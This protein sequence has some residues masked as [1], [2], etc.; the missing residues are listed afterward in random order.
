M[1][2]VARA[3][4]DALV[5]AEA[6]ARRERVLVLAVKPDVKADAAFALA[7]A[8]AVSVAMA[9]FGACDVASE[10]DLRRVLDLEANKQLVGCTDDTCLAEVGDALGAK[11]VVYGSLS[12][13]TLTLK[14]WDIA[15]A[16]VASVVEVPRARASSGAALA[17]ATDTLL[18]PVLAN[19][20]LSTARAGRSP[21]SGIS[22]P[23]DP[24][25]RL[26]AF[27]LRGDV[28]GAVSAAQALPAARRALATA[29]VEVARGEHASALQHLR[30]LRGDGARKNELVSA[31]AQ[32]DRALAVRLVSEVGE[33]RA[34]GL[35]ATDGAIAAS[36]AALLAGTEAPGLARIDVAAALAL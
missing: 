20:G 21:A 15:A 9:G 24:G 16:R 22:L 27:L 35:V 13:K 31:V 14:V 2:G 3:A 4:P 1:V 19:A 12:K 11:I 34:K 8:R 6:R 30:V 29:A 17:E 36:L 25:Q 18:V 28:E 33:A 23:R 32:G 5:K 7:A 10:E 26:R